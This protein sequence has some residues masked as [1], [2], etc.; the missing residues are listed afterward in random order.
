MHSIKTFWKDKNVFVTGCTGFLGKQLLKELLQLGAKV[1]GLTRNSHSTICKEH[2][3]Q[4]MNFVQGSLE[5]LQMIKTTLDNYKIDTVFHMAAQAISGEAIQNPV[6]TFETNIR[7]TWNILEA[8]RQKGVKKVIVTSSE[9]AYGDLSPIPYMETLPLQGRY[10][11]DVSKSCADL[12]TYSYYHTYHLP[13]CIIRCG[14][15]YGEGDLNFSRIIPYTIKSVLQNKAPVIRSD[16]TLVRDFFYIK[17]AVRAHLLL[18]EKM[19][20]DHLVGEAFNFSYE[21]PKTILE[22]VQDILNMMGS[23]L[24]PIIQNEV[25]NETKQQYLTAQK[26]RNLLNWKPNFDYNSGLRRTIEWYR[27]YF[28]RDKKT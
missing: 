14:N 24:M 10:P 28:N 26:T 25:S 13:V 9:K 22:V 23:D 8:C 18:V 5:D 2:L 4:N 27:D 19:E 20:N 11:Y 21:T 7:G 12:I 6:S 1:T 3:Y 16:G 17:D 15:L